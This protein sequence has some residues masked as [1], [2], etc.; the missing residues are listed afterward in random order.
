MGLSVIV[1]ASTHRPAIGGHIGAVVGSALDRPLEYRVSKQI[2]P[3]SKIGTDKPTISGHRAS[4]LSFTT[5]LTKSLPIAG[6]CVRSLTLDQG[7]RI[8]FALKYIFLN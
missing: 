1:K 4:E 6:W 7:T 8:C 5:T 2:G 3:D